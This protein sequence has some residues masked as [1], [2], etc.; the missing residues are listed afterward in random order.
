MAVRGSSE[1]LLAVIEESSTLP[2]GP[3]NCRMGASHAGVTN[4]ETCYVKRRWK[5]VMPNK[6]VSLLSNGVLVSVD[7]RPVTVSVVSAM[8]PHRHTWLKAD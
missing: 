2:G 5:E 8:R 6:G 7:F 1:V 4:S 3:W